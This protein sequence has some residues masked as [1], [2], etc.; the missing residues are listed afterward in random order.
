M[1]GELLLGE[2]QSMRRGSHLQVPE[3]STGYGRRGVLHGQEV[4]GLFRIA[5]MFNWI[6]KMAYLTRRIGQVNFNRA[7]DTL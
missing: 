3:D 1:I 6:L 2:S 5:P 7:T 4:S